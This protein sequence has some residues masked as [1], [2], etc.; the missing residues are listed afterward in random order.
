LRLV[1]TTCEKDPAWDFA[2]HRNAVRRV[3]LAALTGVAALPLFAA[4][5]LPDSRDA[6]SSA[7]RSAEATEPGEFPAGAAP[8]RFVV[9]ATGRGFRWH[10]RRVEP[11]LA[12]NVS[13]VKP[14]AHELRLPVGATVELHLTSDDYVYLLSAPELGIRQI[15]T[16][17]LVHKATFTADRPLTRELPADALC[18]FRFYHDELMGRIIVR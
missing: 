18:N 1:A 9:E 4:W 2:T 3:L 14:P 12:S 5:L 7:G 8:E 11:P 17:G 6:N 10:F 16:P 13:D 15:A